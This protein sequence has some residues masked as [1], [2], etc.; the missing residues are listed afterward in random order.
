MG[1]IRDEIKELKEIIQEKSKDKPKEKVFRLPFGSKVGKLQKKKNYVTLQRINENGQIAFKKVQI[2]EQTFM[3]EGIPRLA[4]AGY[5]TYWKNNPMII[6]PSWSVEPFSPLENYNRS[7]ITG[8]NSAGYRLLMNR[9]KNEQIK[10]K[11]NMGG[12]MKWIIG[13]IVIGIIIYAVM[14]GGGG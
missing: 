7:L 3:D 14:T 10:P 9:M 1:D 6:L 5:V 11:V 2:D 8:T 13:A 12:W 4:A